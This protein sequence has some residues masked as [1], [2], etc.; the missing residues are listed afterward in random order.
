MGNTTNFAARTEALFNAVEPA[1]E[2]IS[3]D[4]ALTTARIGVRLD[5]DRVEIW[6]FDDALATLTARWVSTPSIIESDEPPVV[7]RDW[8]PWGDGD[9]QPEDLFVTRD[10]ALFPLTLSRQPRGG[11]GI[12]AAVMMPLRLIGRASGAVCV[13]WH[14]EESTWQPD[15]TDWLYSAGLDALDAL[16][17]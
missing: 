8:F 9:V 13:Y 4:A 6:R 7:P 3:L 14:S 17:H 10:A 12:D 15:L 16:G 2:A 1:D 11:D 5:A